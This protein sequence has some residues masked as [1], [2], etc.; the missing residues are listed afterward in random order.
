MPG[1]RK[2]WCEH[3]RE[4]ISQRRAN[5]H[6]AF[7]FNPYP[8][9]SILNSSTST[10]YTRHDDNLGDMSWD[11]PPMGEEPSSSGQG[12]FTGGGLRNIRDWVEDVDDEEDL[13]DAENWT[14]LELDDEDE[15]SQGD[16]EEDFDWDTFIQQHRARHGNLS[17]EEQFG[18]SYEQ[19]AAGGMSMLH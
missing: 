7:L 14:S 17:A 10:P 13:M 11:E 2:Q 1:S 6:R 16:E 18:A 5:Q 19:E 15:S 9:P 3:C 8:T 12:S 4:Y